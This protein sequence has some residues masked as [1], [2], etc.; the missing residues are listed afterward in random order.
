MGFLV[1]VLLAHYI[2]VNK[3]LQIAIS[4]FGAPLESRHGSCEVAYLNLSPGR[5]E[6][7]SL[8]SPYT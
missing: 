1:T 3:A 2:G 5:G 8:L 6:S 4:T 7:L